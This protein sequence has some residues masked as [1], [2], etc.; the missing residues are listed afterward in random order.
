MCM[1][2]IIYFCVMDT[3]HSAIVGI[4]YAVNRC[5]FGLFVIICCIKFL[6][7]IDKR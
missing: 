6:L 4:F 2:K 3:Y 1:V 7:F 5:Y